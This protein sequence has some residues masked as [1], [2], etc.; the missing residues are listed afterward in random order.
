M[1]DAPV[2]QSE[3]KIRLQKIKQLEK[4]GI[5]PFPSWNEERITG[6]DFLD[7]FTLLGATQSV[8][9]AGR[10]MSV[11]MQGGTTFA[12]IKDQS[13][14]VQLF[15]K[16]DQVG[17]TAYSL[18]KNSIDRGD[19]IAATGTPFT[20]KRGEKSLLVT[21]F[22]LLAK[23]VLSLP[24]KWDGLKETE[25]RFRKRYLDMIANDEVIKRFTIKSTLISSIREFLNTRGYLEVET[26]VLQPL[27]GGGLA[28]PFVTRL[29]ALGMDLYLRIS[30]ELYLKRLVVGGLEKVY[31]I[32]K[33]FR[34]EGMDHDHNPEFTA[35]ETMAA[36]HNYFYN[37]DLIEECYEFCAQKIL[38]TT[39]IPYGEHII[40]LARPW[41]RM[42][43]VDAIREHTGVDVSLWHDQKS[44]AGELNKL[45]I[46]KKKIKDTHSVGRAIALLFEERVE[47][48]L[49][50]PTI[51][52]EHPVETSPL[53]KRVPGNPAFVERFE[54]FILGSEHGNH[55]TELN[56]PLELAERF[57]EE[58]KKAKKGT[59]VEDVHQ[60]DNDF[61][62]AMKHGMPPTSGL[63]IGIDRM[64]MLF[65]NAD[66]IKEVIPFP[67]LRPKSSK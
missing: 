39:D 51:I 45:K 29:N 15:F 57:V 36:Y 18:L 7:R 32:G 47:E 63:S 35:L 20:T 10:I 21:A 14:S 55:Y 34:N 4:E 12:H 58:Q 17:E 53:A 44:A 13:A 6:Q 28:R 31:E 3:E 61:L 25:T 66:N 65:T 5:N 19:I 38:G 59:A 50:Q 52:Y 11:R 8:T 26:P 22:T 54:H 40:H 27:Y 46:D 64:A 42:T 62:D 16:K 23:S 9:L 1:A 33:V 60:P 49:I 43:M 37:M 30:P 2:H 24:E 48:K 56:D 41:T 67:V